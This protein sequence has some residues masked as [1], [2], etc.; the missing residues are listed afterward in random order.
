[1]DGNG[2]AYVTGMTDSANFPTTPG[3]YDSSYNEGSYDA[4]VAKLNP[5]GSALAYATFLGGSDY[6]QATGI[7]VDGS[8]ATYVAS[9][10]YSANFPTTSGAYDTSFNG[11]PGAFVA[12]LNPAGSALVYATFVGGSG[13]DFVQ[14]IAVDG[15][16]AAYFTGFTASADFPTTPG[17]YDTSFNG[18]F[19]DAFVSKLNPAG[20]ALAYSTFLGGSLMDETYAIAVDASGATYVTGFLASADFPT[21]PG[22]Y[23]TSFGGTYDAFVVKLN[24]AGSALAY[25]TYLG[26]TGF[27]VGLGIA[28][29]G[30]G[31]AYVTGYTYDNNFPTTPGAYDTSFNGGAYDAIVTKLVP[32]G[33]PPP[34]AVQPLGPYRSAS[35]SISWAALATWTG[36][37]AAS[38]DV[39]Y[40]DGASGDWTDLL[41]ATPNTSTNFTGGQDGRIYYF[42]ARSRTAM[43]ALGDWSEAVSTTVDLTAPTASLSIN[44]GA[45]YVSQAGVTLQASANDATSGVAQMQFSNDGSSWSP[46]EGYGTAKSWTLASGDGTKAVYARFR[47]N[48]GNISA[49]CSDTI[50]LISTVGNAAID[51]DGG[52]LY[53]RVP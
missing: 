16:G 53:T 31:G 42:R 39:Q 4:F 20:A 17:A 51:I 44:Y 37:A 30:S 26:G 12:K 33:V 36:T 2:A 32:G 10:T 5:A 7:A 41:S 1:M 25:S 6:D 35:F 22:A 19:R 46:W 18:G 21:T 48:A 45:T 14:G 13:G 8:G 27:D 50:T 40:R 49:I 15:S 52:D 34:V 28:V 23:D 11:R 9:T 24:P 29:D 43:G 3:A 47:D 38:Y